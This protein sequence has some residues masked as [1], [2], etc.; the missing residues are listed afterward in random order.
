MES[1]HPPMGSPPAAGFED[2]MGHQTPAAPTPSV[3]VD[4]TRYYRARAAA[5]ASAYEE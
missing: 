1:N 2:R 5:V 3:V 4:P